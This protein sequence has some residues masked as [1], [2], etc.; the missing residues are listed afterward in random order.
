MLQGRRRPCHTVPDAQPPPRAGKTRG[1]WVDGSK[2]NELQRTGKHGDQCRQNRWPRCAAR[3]PGGHPL[4]GYN[5]TASS[6]RRPRLG[7]ASGRCCWVVAI[8]CLPAHGT[9]YCA[10]EQQGDRS[11]RP[12]AGKVAVSGWS[13]GGRPRGQVPSR[14]AKPVR[15]REIRRCHW[16]PLSRLLFKLHGCPVRGDASTGQAATRLYARTHA[17]GLFEFGHAVCGS[18]SEVTCSV[19]SLG[20]TSHTVLDSQ[21]KWTLASDFFG[22]EPLSPGQLRHLGHGHAWPKNC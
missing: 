15:L 22:W 10:W 14:A 8:A 6:A 2:T 1:R 20:A 21:C 7:W 19:G 13:L 3:R 5:C 18:H 11:H 16:R 12:V 9:R 17:C 4:A